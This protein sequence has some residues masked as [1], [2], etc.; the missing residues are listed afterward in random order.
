MSGEETENN[1]TKEIAALNTSVKA[2][3]DELRTIKCRV[4]DS[5]VNSQSGMKHGAINSGNSLYAGSQDRDLASGQDLPAKRPRAAESDTEE[6][7]NNGEPQDEVED[8]L[9]TLSEVASTFLET[10]FKS[11]ID[12]LARRTKIKKSGIPDS[13]WTRCPNINAVVLANISR[14]VERTDRTTSRLQ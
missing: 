11:T 2:I 3:L 4:T 10:A 12:N 14:D 5:N 13:R 6:F 8:Q 9:V 7:E 1:T